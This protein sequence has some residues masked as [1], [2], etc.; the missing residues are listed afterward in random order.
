MVKWSNYSKHKHYCIR[1]LYC[2]SNQ[3][4]RM[5]ERSI[6]CNYSYCKC[7]TGYTNYC[8]WWSDNF[9]YRWKCNLILKRRNKLLVVKWSHH[10]Q[11]NRY[12]H[13]KLYCKGN[14]WEWVSE[15]SLSS[16]D[17][18]SKFITLNSDN[19]CKRTKNL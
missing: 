19:Y 4:K 12:R 14:K 7:F 18:N 6:S 1:R 13:G 3:C 9:L 17:N 10:F 15:C 8:P 11:Y 16:Q 5:S 2:K